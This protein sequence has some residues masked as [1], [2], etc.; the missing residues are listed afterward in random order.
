MPTSEDTSQ[1]PDHGAAAGRWR[2]FWKKYRSWVGAVLTSIVVIPLGTW[3]VGSAMHWFSHNFEDYVSAVVTVPSPGHSCQGGMGWVFDKEPQQLPGLPVKDND[4]DEWAKVYGGIPASD[5]YIE[6]T[7]HALNGHKVTVPRDGGISVEIKSR[8]EPP[9]GTY[10]SLIGGCGGI[11]P[12]RFQLNLDA[13]PVSITAKPDE[14]AVPGVPRLVDLP[15]EVG[16]EAEVWNLAAVTQTCTCE[17]TA[18][19]HW[20]AEDGTEG[21]TPLNDKDHPFFRV[22]AVTRATAVNPD[23]HGG[24]V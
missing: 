13:N 16:S 5:N 4:L 21:T 9:H 24:W 20:I 10:P 3:A 22:A 6:V 2:A 23:W 14:G 15:H 17:W 7:L 18:T 12:Y 8:S 11:L 1:A 19:L